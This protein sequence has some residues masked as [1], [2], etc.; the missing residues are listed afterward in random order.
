MLMMKRPLAFLA[1]L[2]SAVTLSAAPAS[3]EGFSYI[4]SLGGIDEYRLDA[5]GLQ[6]LLLP[7]RSAPVVTF[8]VTYRVGSRNE[9]TGTTGATHLLEHLMF[10]GSQ[11]YNKANGQIIDRILERTGA[12]YNATT[13]LDRTNYYQ[14]LGSEHLDMVIGMEADRMRNLILDDNERKPEMTVVRN[15][16]ERGENSPFQALIKEMMAAAYQA[17]PYHHNTIGWRSDIEKVSIE[18][19]REFYDT[20]YWP[21]NATV[22]VLGDFTPDQA[23]ALVKK[24]Y[25][26]IPQSP[27]PIPEVYTEEPEQTGPRRV[28]VKRA[29]QLGVVAVGYKSIGGLH[30]DFAALNVLANILGDGQNSRLYRALTDKTL[31]TS[32]SPYNGYFHDPTLLNI[33][34]DARPRRHPRPGRENH[35]RGNREGEEGRR[36][37]TG[38]RRRHRQAPHRDCLQ[39]RRLLRH[40]RPPQRGHRRRRLAE[41][42]AA[43]RALQDHHPRH[44]AEHRGEIL[45]REPEHHRLVRPPA[46]RRPETRR[47]QVNPSPHS[48]S[49]NRSLSLPETNRENEQANENDPALSPMKFL[50]RLPLLALTLILASAVSA[51]ADIASTAVRTKVAGFDLIAYKTGVKDVVYLRGALPAGDNKAPADHPYLPTLVGDMLDRGTTLHDKAWITAQLDAVG[52]SISFSVNTGV[53]EFNARCLAQDVPLVVALLAEQLRHPAFAAE[54]RAKLQKQTVGNIKRSL[55]NTGSRAN[56][57]FSRAA[58]PVGHPN[59][60]ATTAENIASVEKATVAELQAF[61]AAHYGPAHLT[62]IAV[63]DIDVPQIEQQLGQAFAGWTGGSAP[64]TTA[65]ASPTDSAREHDVVMPDKPSVN[66]VLGQTT[67]LRYGEA[68]Y[69]ALRAGASV[70]G[71]ASFSGRLM[72]NTRE[73]EGLTYGIYSNL[74]NDM[75]NDGDFRIT[76]TFAPNLLDK[77]VASARKHLGEWY[78]QGVTA[79][80]LADHQGNLTGSFK[81]ALSTTDG[82][83]QALLN[84]VNRGQSVAWLDEYPVK[85]NALTVAEV[86]G[87]IKKHLNPEKMFLVKAGTIPGAVAK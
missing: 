70:L 4:K 14:T 34:A 84:A 74:T 54:E 66:V 53:L 76:A 7:D 43:P 87:A 68:D 64:L 15:E 52:A 51:S 83:A 58:Y 42:R 31:T 48:L 79:Q 81:I 60:Q 22:S 73:K 61:H 78:Q 57:E 75:F 46:A 29:G 44:G 37:P 24:H 50:S 5:N 3:V 86:N 55:E 59:R 80:E 69:L 72:K 20:F 45:Q 62:I 1:L 25:G 63:G 26:A 77:G 21:N 27:R 39:P 6:V 19:L 9:V 28:T 67:G 16:F 47:R 10:K 49:L 8:M 23:L 12:Q 85:I 32:V 33:Y 35:P 38:D 30:P 36:H 40:R 41:L 82:M 71:G 13:W 56:D 18:K 65:K 17:H 2:V 11:N